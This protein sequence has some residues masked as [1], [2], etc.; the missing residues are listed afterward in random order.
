MSTATQNNNG[1]QNSQ[2]QFVIQRFLGHPE[3][4]FNKQSNGISDE[5]WQLKSEVKLED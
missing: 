2:N 5:R 4:I 3:L 1:G